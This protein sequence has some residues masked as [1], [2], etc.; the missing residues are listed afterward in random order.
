MK[1][2]WKNISGTPLKKMF[3]RIGHILSIAAQIMFW[4]VLVMSFV[5]G[6]CGLDS[7][8]DNGCLWVCAA[9]IFAPF[10]VGYVG[11]KKF[12]MGKYLDMEE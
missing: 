4:G 10:I 8:A 6:A 9:L 5:V 12:G 2:F 3:K 1:K 11:V 7:C